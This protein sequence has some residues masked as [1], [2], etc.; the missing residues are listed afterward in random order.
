[1]L[2]DLDIL[3]CIHNESLLG[4]HHILI[5]PLNP[6]RLQPASYDVAL[7]DKILQDEDSYDITGGF[8]LRPQQFILGSLV[9]HLELGN[10]IAARIEG[11]SSWGRKGLL[12]HATAGFID[13]GWRGIITLE[14]ANLSS[15][16]IVL[17]SGMLI[18]QLSFYKLSSPAVR[19]YGHPSLQSKYQGATGV[20][21][22]KLP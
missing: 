16:P 14:L 12:V 18:A 15:K 6:E 3:N 4:D 1:M 20:E 9:E 17:T 22:S 2:S 11:K 7:G 10:A 8:E 19:P 21:A 5:R 13:P